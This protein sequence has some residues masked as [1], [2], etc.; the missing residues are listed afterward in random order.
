MKKYIKP[1]IIKNTEVRY[2]V[3]GKIMRIKRK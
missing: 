3:D 2:G 1:V